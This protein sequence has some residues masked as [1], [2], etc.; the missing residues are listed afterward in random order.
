MREASPQ[1]ISMSQDTSSHPPMCQRDCAWSEK[2]K[3]FQKWMILWSHYSGSDQE[4][5]LAPRPDS[6]KGI[7]SP[8]AAQYHLYSG[9]VTT[10]HAVYLPGISSWPL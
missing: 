2:G 9:L 6:W 4:T 10:A 3:M 8:A 5:I 7:K 1:C